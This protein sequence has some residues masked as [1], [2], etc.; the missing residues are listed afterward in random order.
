[1]S[2][3][4]EIVFT[5]AGVLDLLANIEEFN[6]FD[7]GLTEGLDGTLQLQVNDSVYE[8]ASEESVVDIDVPEDVVDEVSEI[9]ET[10]YEALVDDGIAN[11]DEVIESGLIKEALK[12]LL[13]GGVV[14][15]GKKLL[16]D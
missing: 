5:P 7:L 13:V 11:T 4:T 9:N 2:N 15:L 10:A 14:R 16:T 6:E 8:L 1:M 12:T 3:E